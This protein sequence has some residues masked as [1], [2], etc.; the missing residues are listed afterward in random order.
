MDKTEDIKRICQEKQIRMIDFKMTDIDGRWRHITVPVERFGADTFTQGIGFDGSNYGY[1]PIEK[2][3]MVFLPDPDTAYVDPFAAVPTLTMCGNVCTIGKGEN[4]PFDQYPKNVAL[5]AVHYMKNNG[6]A[7]RMVIGPEFEFYLF[8]S[9]RFEVTPRQCGYRIDTRQADWNHSLDTAGNNGYEVSHKGGY[10]IA[11]PQDVG[12]D[13]RSRMCMMME[14]WGIRVKY[15]HHEVGGPGQMEIEVEL[16]DMPSMADNTMIIKYI[17]KNLAA[18]EG[19]TAT[20]LPKP[21]YQEAGSGMHVHMLLFK[22]GKPLFYGRAAEAH[23]LP[24]RL[25][26][27]LHQ[28]LQAPGAGI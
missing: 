17:I 20:F 28:F 27:S 2:S 8:D 14:D 1:A 3:D 21:I 15:H 13:L 10:H 19:K 16:D 23:C 25:H 7:D 18:Q 22:D 26:Q 5:S 11:A 4:K 9:A 24:L 12:Y 6:I